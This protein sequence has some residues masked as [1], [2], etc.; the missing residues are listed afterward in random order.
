MDFFSSEQLHRLRENGVL[1][2]D[3][4]VYGAKL[5]P[6][7]KLFTP[8]A[9][10]TWLVAAI[11][12]NDGDRVLALCD[13]ADGDPQIRWTSLRAL[14]ALRGKLGK[15]VERDD[16]FVPTATLGAYHD[17]ARRSGIVVA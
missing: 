11:H 4:T 5:E 8:D 13:V 7:A 2:L 16:R 17:E 9:G 3:R 10:C 14:A 1:W 12:P 15:A 6:V